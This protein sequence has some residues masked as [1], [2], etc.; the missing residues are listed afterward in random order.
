M[1]LGRA[2][3]IARANLVRLLR[4]RLGLFFIVVLPLMIIFVTGLQF[5]GGFESRVGLL[6]G[7]SGPLATDLAERLDERWQIERYETEDALLDA[8]ERGRVAVGVLLPERYDERVRDG[9]TVS[10]EYV[11]ASSNEA[12][13]R[14]RIVEAMVAEQS[15]VVRA[16]RFAAAQAGGEASDLL[17]DAAALQDGLPALEVEVLTVGESAFPEELRG[18]ALGAQGQLVLFAF[19]T[20]LTGAAQ[21]IVSR[22]LGVSRRMLA[23]PTSVGT[24]LLGEALGRFAVALFQAVFIVAATALIFG[25]V[26]GD[27]LGATVLVM[28]FS[29]VA[30]GVAMLIG[31]V[32]NNA[33]QAGSIGVFAGLGVAAIGGSMVPPEIF[34]E[35][36]A[37]ISWFTPHR[38]ALD[39]FRELIVGAD[40]VDILPQ[41]GVLFG[42]AA[43][44][45][46]LATW[47]LR[48]A[49]TH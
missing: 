17:D 22:Q 27:P 2:L 4:D 28:A 18:F 47:R 16:A 33:E 15:A 48:A 7:E 39:G 36:M 30:A 44:V 37:T 13:G 21:L 3:V 35:P 6:S 42:L 25:V 9:E 1:S 43:I 34:P 38:W 31:A 23:T 45:L 19:L 40:L 8:V 12:I 26:W 32:A 11:A 5:G 49:L 29:L 10:V 41:L 20:S 46:A 24:I 14:R